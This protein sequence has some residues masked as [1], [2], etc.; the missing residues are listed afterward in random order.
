MKSFLR[1][2]RFSPIFVDAKCFRTLISLNTH[3]LN[4]SEKIVQIEEMVT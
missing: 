3:L 1:F 2:E 4:K